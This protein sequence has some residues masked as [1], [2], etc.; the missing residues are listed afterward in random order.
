MSLFILKNRYL[1]TTNNLWLSYLCGEAAEECKPEVD[2][3]E[4]EVFVEEVP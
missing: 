2:E 3:G 1:D 4:S